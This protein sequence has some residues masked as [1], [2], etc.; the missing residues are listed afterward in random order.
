MYKKRSFKKKRMRSSRIK[1]PS[2]IYK[3][4]VG[5]RYGG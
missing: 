2:S 4:R 1:K 5:R 3:Y